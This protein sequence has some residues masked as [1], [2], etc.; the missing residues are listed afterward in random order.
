VL[1]EL[2]PEFREAR[3]VE[4]AGAAS[5]RAS[6]MSSTPMED[7]SN[8][9]C[10]ITMRRS[11]SISSR[12]SLADKTERSYRRPS[13]QR[14][15]AGLFSMRLMQADGTVPRIGGA[16]DGKSIRSVRVGTMADT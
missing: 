14:W 10:F 16:D 7:R 6:R 8:N 12:R 5:N 15:S 9:R 13:G 11:A 4:A 2:F 1:A 3:R